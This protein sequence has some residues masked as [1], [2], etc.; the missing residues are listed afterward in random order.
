MELSRQID[1]AHDLV[2]SVAGTAAQSIAPL[3]G[4][5]VGR[6]FR[7]DT[8]TASYL[9]KL[10]DWR[11][12]PSF[13][14][15]PVD[16]RVYGSRFGNLQPAHEMLRRSG[17]PTPYLYGAGARRDRGVSYAVFD[18][19]E[20]A[21]DDFSVTWFAAVGAA[22]RELHSIGRPYQG[23]VA[24]G[25]PLAEPWSTA[26]ARALAINFVKAKPVLPPQLI[27]AIEQRI[28]EAPAI[29]EPAAFVLSHTDGFQ[30]VLQR[31]NGDWELLGHVDVE[32]MQFTDRRF[33]MTGFE[34]AHR[35]NG[36]AVPDAFW[37]AYGWRPDVRCVQFELLYLLVW[38]RVVRDRP[39]SFTSCLVELERTVG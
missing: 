36:H 16:D 22:L 29:D 13:A 30:A 34:L 39:E 37:R 27:R 1:L 17:L 35:L 11:A 12:E 38:A 10:V 20:G 33:V 5:E 9:V 4:G 15:E 7:A 6:V 26:F 24:M 8:A 19:L 2:Q 21:D 14:D 28:R 18:Y 32:D 23:W 3:A 25:A 31:R